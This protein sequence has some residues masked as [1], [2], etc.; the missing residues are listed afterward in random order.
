MVSLLGRRRHCHGDR[1]GGDE[2]TFERADRTARRLGG[3]VADANVSALLSALDPLKAILLLDGNFD[4]RETFSECA[5]QLSQK[6]RAHQAD[7]LATSDRLAIGVIDAA[8]GHQLRVPQDLAVV[9]FDDIPAAGLITPRLTT[10]RQPMAEKGGSAVLRL[11][12][13]NAQ[14]RL[15]LPAELIV[16]ES[17]VPAIPKADSHL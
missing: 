7:V 2:P 12:K 6:G 11:L 16:R 1:C 3:S 8:A 13:E 4:F 10:V 9:G 14:L 17:T 5:D 15:K